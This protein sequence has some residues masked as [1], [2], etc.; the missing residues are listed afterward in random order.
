MTN[1]KITR[2][3]FGHSLGAAAVGGMLQPMSPKAA[4]GDDL[5]ALSALELA[6]R[7]RTKQVS[8]REVMIAHLARIEQVNPR[9]N[10]IVRSEERRVGK[11]CR[12]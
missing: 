3:T 4:P 5:C 6:G 7:I 1:T 9:V 2:R 8:A 12:L 10:A 11:E